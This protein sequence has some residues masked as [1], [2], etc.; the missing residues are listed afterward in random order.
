MPHNGP[1]KIK[2][3]TGFSEVSLSKYFLRSILK[4]NENLQHPP[5]PKGWTVEESDPAGMKV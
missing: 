2:S 4:R 5:P 3:L 1:R